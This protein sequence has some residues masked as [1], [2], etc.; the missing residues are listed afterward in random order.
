[1]IPVEA[2]WQLGMVERHGSVLGDI[3]TAIV[4]EVSPVGERQMK[5]VCFHASFVKIPM[6]QSLRQLPLRKIS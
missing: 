5:D 4:M 6:S 3:I 2:P 1:M